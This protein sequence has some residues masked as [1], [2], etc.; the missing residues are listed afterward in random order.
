MLQTQAGLQFAQAVTKNRGQVSSEAI[1]K[2][3]DAG[4]NDGD[5][6]EIVLECS[7]KYTNQLCESH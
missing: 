2:V 7:F 4:Y 1:Q 6:L 3:K 5:I